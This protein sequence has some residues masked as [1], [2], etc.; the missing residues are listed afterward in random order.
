MD[1]IRLEKAVEV[2]YDEIIAD[3]PQDKRQSCP[4]V[5]KLGRLLDNMKTEN[6]RTLATELG[7]VGDC[8]GCG[9]RCLRPK[10]ERIPSAARNLRLRS[11]PL[12]SH[13]APFASIGRGCKA[14]EGPHRSHL[15]RIGHDRIIGVAA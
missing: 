12:Q 14:S 13:S 7:I 15:L 4:V 10:I 11:W 1:D 2:V 3:V 6:N 5:I 9:T 8:E